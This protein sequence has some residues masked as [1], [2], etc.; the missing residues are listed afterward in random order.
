MKSSNSIA[1]IPILDSNV[2]DYDAYV[3]S[4][5]SFFATNNPDASNLYRAITIGIIP[6]YCK[7]TAKEPNLVNVRL[8]ENACANFIILSE[9]FLCHDYYSILINQE[10]FSTACTTNDAIS[11]FKLIKS[12]HLGKDQQSNKYL[13]LAKSIRDLFNIK[14]Q[15]NELLIDF[16]SRFDNAITLIKNHNIKLEN[17]ADQEGILIAIFMMSIGSPYYEHLVS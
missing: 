3:R 13:L 1:N 15:S 5:L 12:H 4:L 9:K 11:A 6:E 2:A 14:Q 7:S 17:N 8:W 10:Y 16:I